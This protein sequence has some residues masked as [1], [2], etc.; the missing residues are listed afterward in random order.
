MA[1]DIWE[2]AQR[3]PPAERQAFM[4]WAMQEITR[5]RV[6]KALPTAGA[7]A[8]EFDPKN[9]Q[10]ADLAM[11]DEALEWAFNTPDARLMI[12]K[13]SQ[14]GKSERVA[15]WGMVRAL[16]RNPDCRI[17]IATHSEDLA[18]THSER[19][20]SILAAHGTGARDSQTGV[21]LPDRLGI[22][23][24]A[25]NAAS[26][27]TLAGHIG[28]VVAVGVGTALPGKPAD[29]LLLDDLYAGME[30]ADSPAYR[31]RVNLWWDTVASQ[32]PGPGAPVIAIG[33]RW[34]EYDAHAYLMEKHPGKWRVLNFPA[35]AEKGLDD[36][37]GREP[38]VFLENPRG[39]TDWEAIRETKPARVWAS[40]YQGDP[41]PSDGALFSATWFDDHRVDVAPP[42]YRRIVG[43]DPA[44]TGT[45]DEAGIIAG[46][47]DETGRVVLTDDASGHLSSAQWPRTA[48]LLALRTAASEVYFEAYSAPK[49]YE[50]LLQRAYDDLVAEAVRLT[51]E[52]PEAER[53]ALAAAGI[54]GV[55]EGVRVPFVRP[56]AIYPW[57]GHGNAVV[58]STGFR[59]GT[60]SGKCRVVGHRLA[61]MERQA[62]RWFEGQHSPDRVSAGTVVFDVLAPSTPAVVTSD[63]GSWGT[64]ASGLA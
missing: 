34:N 21:L 52:L 29:L 47:L 16:I 57:K 17:I 14:T 13:P 9:N 56:F 44:E 41:G 20:R 55:V 8:A 6:M 40:M 58:R 37:L 30:Q 48:C 32:R 61:T 3:L 45:G 25:K 7:L 5:R 19:I 12:S 64:I 50:G 31:R 43:I 46:G 59:H 62:V 42:L 18:L 22:G 60:S 49:T 28:G 4:S 11:I 27:W 35:I 36:A 26:R 1:D 39:Y 51:A 15:V 54:A 53:A 23:L 10:T 33:T 24:G 2:R 38:G 63:P